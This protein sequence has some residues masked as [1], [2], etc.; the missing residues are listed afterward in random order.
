MKFKN[1]KITLPKNVLLYAF[2]ATFAV[3]ALSNIFI[4]QDF[5]NQNQQMNDEIKTLYYEKSFSFFMTDEGK[6]Q[7][8]DLSIQPLSGNINTIE[9]QNK[10]EANKSFQFYFSNNN[11]KY[12]VRMKPLPV[13]ESAE[14][15]YAGHALPSVNAQQHQTNLFVPW[16]ISLFELILTG[17]ILIF[18][19]R[20]LTQPAKKFRDI[21]RE[22]A[23]GNINNSLKHTTGIKGIWNDLA[24]SVN[25]F[26]DHYI[27]KINFAAEIARGNN[28]VTLQQESDEDQLSH[29]LLQIRDRL[30]Q[31]HEDAKQREI[32]EEKRRWANEGIAK[33]ADL[34]RKN[35]D[36][37]EDL[38]FSIISHLVQYLEANQGGLFMLNDNDPEDIFYELKAAYAFN[39][40]KYMNQS[41]RPGDGLVGT[42]ALEG[43]YIYMT[44]IP[45]DYI[46]ITSGLGDANP[47][48]L[49]L[50]PLKTD[51][52]IE[53]VIEIAAFNT[54]ENYQ[55]EFVKKV[56]ESI[57]STISSVKINLKTNQLLQKSQQ[58]AEEMASQDEEMRQNMEEM[59]AT[60][61]E[62]SRKMKANEEMHQEL[63]KEKAL[64]DALM[65]NL[66]DYIYF[67]DK[68]SKFIRVS[69]SMLPLFSVDT[70]EEMI[71]KSDFDFHKQEAA[72]E[73]YEEEQEIM[74]KGKG[75]EDKIQHEITETG[76]D[77]WVSVTKL[78]LYDPEG[79]LMGTFGISKNVTR[80]KELELE[81]Q[82][83]N[84]NDVSNNS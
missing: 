83:N 79:K 77:Q 30:K 45:Q 38:S 82:Q 46:K 29:S 2:V 11:I 66:P 84:Q 64:L 10:L 74:K 65:N 42:C 35:H 4:I 26:T 12:H 16:L 3:L 69:K 13:Q 9:L 21:F 40:K 18:M 51:E 1:R 19:F 50:V 28:N 39:R 53:G 17:F 43:E 20:K 47:D 32:E 75:F 81:A 6:L 68:E 76:K 78:P 31:A 49:L 71:G 55:I 63:S 60:Q 61:E 72:R 44:Y 58:Q 52:K 15:V 5:K 41:V 7:S 80:F 56:A 54:F 67:K 23:T 73:M 48:S 22:I 14:F 70:I 36:N 57:A 27:A 34:L 8:T 25:R 59:Q 62:L 37:L 24:S 33:F